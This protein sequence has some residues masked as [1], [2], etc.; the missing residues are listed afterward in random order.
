MQPLSKLQ[1]FFYQTFADLVFIVHLGLVLLVVFGWLIPALFYFFLGALVATFLSEIF[2]SYCFLSRMEFNLRK[3]I[4][5]AKIYDKSCIVHYTRVLFGLPPRL[6]SVTPVGF[7][8]KNSFKFVL[9]TLFVVSIS[10][11]VLV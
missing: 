4:D 6:A 11:R 10:Y 3:K 9:L 1:K 8:K 7:F 2:L 5:P